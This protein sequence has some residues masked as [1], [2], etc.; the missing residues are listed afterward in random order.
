MKNKFVIKSWV[1]YN[2]HNLNIIKE[3]LIMWERQR[4]R[5]NLD[6]ICPIKFN[7]V[8]VEFDKY[9]FFVTLTDEQ[10]L[11]YGLNRWPNEQIDISPWLICNGNVYNFF[12]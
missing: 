1:N 11:T 6:N 2:S 10:A 8:S 5:K 4:Y 9:M 12:K 7:S 3:C